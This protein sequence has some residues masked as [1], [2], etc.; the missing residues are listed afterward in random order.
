[1]A[2]LSGLARQGGFEPD[3]VGQIDNLGVV[4]GGGFEAQHGE[5][6]AAFLQCEHEIVGDGL[7]FEDGGALEFATHACLRDLR[8]RHGEERLGFVAPEHGAHVRLGLAGDDVHEGG[9]ARPVG[10]DNR[11]HFGVTDLKREVVD[12][13]EPVK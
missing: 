10:A 6:T 13:L 8:F 9:L 3:L 5:R 12:G 7:I 1:M 11:A 4:R 2:Q